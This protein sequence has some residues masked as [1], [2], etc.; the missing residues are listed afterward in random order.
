M[1]SRI[2]T[3]CRRRCIACHIHRLSH[4]SPTWT[5]LT[6]CDRTPGA[7]IRRA[8]GQ[9]NRPSRW[10]VWMAA[11][12]FHTSPPYPKLLHTHSS[13]RHFLLKPPHVLYDILHNATMFTILRSATFDRWLD[14]LRDRQAIHRIVARLLAVEDGHLGDVRTVGGGVSEMKIHHGPGYRIYFIP[15]DVKLIVLLCAGDKDSQR[16]DIERAK[17]MAKEWRR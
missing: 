16:R 10:W 14:R 5:T 8:V 15:R 6:A 12:V 9:W 17:Q 4:S 11:G 7:D 1:N 3:W 13:L 2:P